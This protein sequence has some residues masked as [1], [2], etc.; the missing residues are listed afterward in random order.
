MIIELGESKPL[1]IDLLYGP[2]YPICKLQGLI[3][4]QGNRFQI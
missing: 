1:S 3:N 2:C 4:S